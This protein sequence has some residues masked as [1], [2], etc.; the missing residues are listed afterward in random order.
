MTTEFA[1]LVPETRHERDRTERVRHAQRV[2]GELLLEF[3]IGPH[4]A[5]FDPL[6]H[7]IRILAERDRAGGTSLPVILQPTIGSVCGSIAW[8]HAV[9]DAIS[10]GFL[11]PDAIH[12]WAF[13]F[14]K[15]PTGAEFICTLAELVHDRI[16]EP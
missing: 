6:I 14:S 16:A 1:G 9:R 11:N 12:T 5:G 10:V 3:G 2:T 8:E 7:G 15:R 13:P 4:L